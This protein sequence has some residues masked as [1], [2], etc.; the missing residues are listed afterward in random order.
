MKSAAIVK[1]ILWKT[2]HVM[3]GEMMMV[4]MWKVFRE[5]IW[6]IAANA[7]CRIIIYGALMFQPDVHKPTDM[8]I[9]LQLDVG[10]NIIAISKSQSDGK[11]AM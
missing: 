7:L 1:V 2:N 10:R 6:L 8:L 4:L 11:S 9:S 5:K 3:S